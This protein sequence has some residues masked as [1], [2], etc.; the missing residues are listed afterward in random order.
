MLRLHFSTAKSS[1]SSP[2][3]AG[4]TANAT[5][6]STSVTPTTVVTTTTNATATAT[7]NSAFSTTANV[8]TSAAAS[9]VAAPAAVLEGDERQLRF[10]G[11]ERHHNASGLR[12]GGERAA[13]LPEPSRVAQ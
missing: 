5:I 11:S 4:R 6:N 7:R 2:P 13:T 8:A 1:C 12:P 9:A 10:M 3:I